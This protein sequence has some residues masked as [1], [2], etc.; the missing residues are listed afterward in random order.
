GLPHIVDKDLIGV[1]VDALLSVRLG[2]REPHFGNLVDP[3]IGWYSPLGED[4]G[5][6]A[7][8]GGD[9]DQCPSIVSD[10]SVAHCILLLRPHFGGLDG[11]SLAKPP[12]GVFPRR[13]ARFSRSCGP[14]RPL[15][16]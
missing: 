13:K 8:H 1:P 9:G 12:N 14:E 11:T 4:G 16:G 7:Q 2:E 6:E 5:A 15:S 3:L 10:I